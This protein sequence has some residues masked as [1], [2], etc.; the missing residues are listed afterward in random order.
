M[1]FSPVDREKDPVALLSVIS[2]KI[3]NECLQ[4]LNEQAHLAVAFQAGV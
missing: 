3:R 2:A 4:M 1:R